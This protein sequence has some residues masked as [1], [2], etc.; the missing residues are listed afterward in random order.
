M[1]FG[2]SKM[3]QMVAL[4]RAWRIRET[5][6]ESIS[7]EVVQSVSLGRELVWITIHNRVSNLIMSDLYDQTT[8][9]TNENKI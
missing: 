1:I 2:L 9:T 4:K 3:K 5:I 7:Y 6:G 8:Y